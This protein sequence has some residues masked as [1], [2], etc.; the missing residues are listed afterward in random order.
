MA[1][2]FGQRTRAR[3][4]SLL[5]WGLGLALLAWFLSGTVL[6]VIL[7]LGLV[8]FVH[9]LGHFLAC[10]ATGVKVEVFSIGFGPALP[11]LTWRWGET[12]FKVAAIPLGGYVKMLGENPDEAADESVRD[13]PRAYPNRPVGQR[14][15]IISGGV[16]MNV[17]FGLVC[18]VVVYL[19][20]KVE[21]AP[22]FGVIV[23][24]SPADMAGL[25]TGSLLLQVNDNSQPTYEDLFYAAALAQPDRTAIYLRWQTPAHDGE[26]GVVKEA[27]V[28]P[29]RRG[30]ELKPTLGVGFPEGLSLALPYP[31]P[32][33][34][35][36]Q[37][38][39]RFLALRP[40]GSDRSQALHTH[41]DLLDAQFRWRQTELEVTI[42]RDGQ[43]HVYLV[44]PRYFHTFGVE[45]VIGPIVSVGDD[46]PEPIRRQVKP[47]DI[48]VAVNDRSDFDPLRLPDELA[49]AGQRRQEVRLAFRRH[50]QSAPI[51]LAVV[52]LPGRGSWNEEY[53]V[54]SF[55][56]V[57]IPALGITYDVS[58]R[59]GR[60]H[61][62]GPA[63]GKLKPGDEIVAVTVQT[64]GSK[65]WR[66]DDTVR[67]PY[68]FWR[69]QEIA[70]D[71]QISEATVTV[72]RP[73][74]T[75][76]TVTVSLREDRTWPLPDRGWV[77]ERDTFVFR[78]ANPFQAMYLGTRDTFRT[79]ARIYIQ[80]KA[81]VVGQI[82][83]KLMSGPPEI[84]RMTYHMARRGLVELLM[85]LGMISIN[86]A[87]INFL[88]IPLLDGGHM[89][90]LIIEKLRQ[91]PVRWQIQAAA[92]IIG[93]VLLIGL[94][95][96]LTL[97]DI[98]KYL[99]VGPG[100]D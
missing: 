36:M 52:P 80:I 40:K 98:S 1:Q 73:E 45:F 30:N 77:M 22:R 97:W 88:P 63:H 94:M 66:L 39:D 64:D 55:A 50:G 29:R 74:G 58:P 17:L 79:V 21:V 93:L 43:E 23:P 85:F 25:E 69:L 8:I 16:L 9:E 70:R 6:L 92:N 76:E 10:K 33:G 95:V 20:G 19:C 68:V 2:F 12:E 38:G 47:G 27:W 48:L 83:W 99:P 54:T 60:V 3:L 15:W 4:G 65:S 71:S 46:A 59:I 49:E 89:V 62:D 26:S 90:F 24:G 34:T 42:Q 53:P 81:L 86:L 5:T 13:D 35:T 100:K 78:T 32:D 37:P 41:R 75:E 14:M 61:P 31:L 44:P 56:P 57:S 67:L 91:R 82:S 84:A 87:V 72:R 28:V 51:E 96:F 18:F 11:G 7:G